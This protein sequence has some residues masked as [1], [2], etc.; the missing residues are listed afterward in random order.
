MQEDEFWKCFFMT[1]D[2]VKQEV[3]CL[4][5]WERLQDQVKQEVQTESGVS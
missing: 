5:S 3:H 2:K 1:F 4:D